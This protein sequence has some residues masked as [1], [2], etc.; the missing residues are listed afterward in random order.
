MPCTLRAARAALVCS[1]LA[2]VASAA[3]PSDRELAA[4]DPAPL[5]ALP[6]SEAVGAT[7]VITAEEI[8]RS[9]AANVFD[10][11][12]R[13]PGVDIRYTPMGG[14]IGIRSTGSSPFTEQVLMLIDGSPYNS[15]DKGGFPGHPNYTGFFPLDRIERIEVI[16]GPISVLYGA[17]AFAGVIN[18]VTKKAADAVTDRI[19]GSAYGGAL[20]AGERGTFERRALV[21]LIRGGWETTIDV[22]AA[23]GDT[24]IRLNGEARHHRAN[25]YLALQRGNFRTSVLHQE[26][27]FGEFPFEDTQTLGAEHSVDIVDAH[28]GRRVG[29]FVLRGSASL[30]RYHGTTCANC[31]NNQSGPPDDAWT[32]DVGGERET[33]QRLRLALRADRA[34]TDRQDLTAGAETALDTVRRDIVRQDDA[35]PELY[36]GGLYVQHQLHLR[37]RRLHLVSGVRLDSAERLGLA[38]SPRV[39]VVLE[40]NPDWVVRGSWSRAFRAPTWNERYIRQRFDPEELAPGLILVF[41]GN[42]ELD[43]ERND[44][45]EAGFSWRAHDKL[46]LRLDLFH[47]RIHDF[48]HREGSVFLP[49]SP[50]ELR[51][52]Y[53]NR[54][55]DFSVR[56]GELT[57]QAQPRR[58]LALTAAFGHRDVSLDHDDPDAAY[59]PLRRV[60]LTAGFSPGSRWSLDLSGS[61][62]GSYTVSSP[63]VFGLRPQ[64]SY[65]LV[66][67]AV[68]YR[69]PV[70]RGWIGFG[71]IGRNVFDAHPYETLV[72]DGVDTSLRGRVVALEVRAGL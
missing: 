21:E 36:S 26:S 33:D 69:L 7:T 9:G 55:D 30:N 5:L 41:Q 56:G 22:G 53:A 6:L 10:L 18:V 23:D 32:D 46:T 8:A 62:S 70:R 65:E 50:N 61:H 15:P 52:P 38:T 40:P 14:H 25:A 71:L 54:S 67:A 17:N 16:K 27:R 1:T 48:I 72:D 2:G 44:S 58:D 11:L 13:V 28:Y 51:V 3:D 68:R 59:S 39:A 49:G 42:P 19:E 4:L 31:H 34:L 60:I 64:P 66:D 37:Q 24:P 47:N 20:A 63:Q 43:R 35:P 57:I 12:R 45:A 29:G